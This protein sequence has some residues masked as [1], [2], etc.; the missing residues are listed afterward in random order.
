MFGFHTGHIRTQKL[1]TC[2]CS[3]SCLQHQ[4]EER[5]TWAFTLWRLSA[6]FWTQG[7]RVH[8]RRGDGFLR[9]IRIRS[10]SSFGWE[11]KPE[12]P[13][14]KILRHVKDPVRY[15]MYWIGKILTP[16]SI[17]PNCPRCLCWQDCQRALVDE[18]GV[19]F[20]RHY[21]EHGTPCSHITRGMNSRPVGVRSSETYSLTASYSI[22]QLISH[23]ASSIKCSQPFWNSKGI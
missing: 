10:T 17:P 22:K 23:P 11:V 1:L 15:L 5:L 21:H 13:R 3:A 2:S 6:S 8:T 12:I 4:L 19:I 7:S 14:R 16:S 9:A 18:S 20:S